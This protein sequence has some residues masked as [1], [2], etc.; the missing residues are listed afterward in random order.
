MRCDENDGLC[1]RA[2]GDVFNVFCIANHNATE[3]GEKE[4]K[5]RKVIRNKNE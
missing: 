3:K 1:V 5:E 2:K 4:K